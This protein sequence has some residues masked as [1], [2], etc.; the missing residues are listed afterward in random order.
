VCFVFKD[1]VLTDEH[2]LAVLRAAPLLKGVVLHDVDAAKTACTRF[3]EETRAKTFQESVIKKV[4]DTPRGNRVQPTPSA[5][6]VK[7]DPK[8]AAQRSGRQPRRSFNRS[9]DN[10]RPRPSAPAPVT[11]KAAVP[12]VTA[13]ITYPNTAKAARG[14]HSRGRSYYRSR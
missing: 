12:V 9:R 8:P 5:V 7:Q 2:S 11:E 10:N 13:P 4:L 3:R 6:P 1:E 14:A